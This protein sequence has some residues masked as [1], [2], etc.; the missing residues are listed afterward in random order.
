MLQGVENMNITDAKNW[1]LSKESMSPKKLQKMLYY[2]YAWGLVLLNE[3]PD[4]LENKIFDAEF[5]AWVHGPVHRGT[6]FE[7]REYGYQEIPKVND[8]NL[9]FSV[10]ELDVLNQVYEVYGGYSANELE[11]ITHQEQP[12]LEKREGLEAYE[13]TDRVISDET[14]FRY[15][16]KQLT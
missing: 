5:E 2:C 9:E 10:D 1:L 13:G 6:Y 14:I 7:H 12:W 4:E 15:Y 16:V 11:S 8:F 3:N